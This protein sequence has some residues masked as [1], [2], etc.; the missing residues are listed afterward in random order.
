MVLGFGRIMKAVEFFESYFDKIYVVNLDRRQDRWKHFT[1]QAAKFGLAKF[2]RIRG[3]LAPEWGYLIQE[4]PHC[5][6]N[7]HHTGCTASHR[8]ILDLIDHFEIGRAM[9]F[10]DDVLFRFD[11]TFERFQSMIEEVPKN[12]DLLF[13][14]G[15][16]GD[17]P[18]RRISKHV[19]QYNHM[20]STSSYAVTLRFARI[21][22]PHIGGTN[23]IDNSYWGWS[24]R[25]PSYIFQ[26]RLFSQYE[27][28][29][30]IAGHVANW[31]MCMTD[32]NHENTV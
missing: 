23:P 3:V 13:L 14:G 8:K 1:D 22:A 10:E 32:I 25:E 2:E 27:S 21:M 29:S 31:D 26:P 24:E 4:W 12:W 5:Q 9:V 16:Y 30:D 17:N 11:D 7:N 20:L 19:I 15:H 18:I 6:K 28:F